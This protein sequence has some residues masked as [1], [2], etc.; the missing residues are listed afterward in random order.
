MLSRDRDLDSADFDG[1]LSFRSEVFFFL[2]EDLVFTDFLA[3][4]DLLFDFDLSFFGM[5]LFFFF[6]ILIALTKLKLLPSWYESKLLRSLLFLSSL[7]GDFCLG[8]FWDLIDFDLLLRFLPFALFFPGVLLRSLFLGVLLRSLFLGVLIPS[9]DFE[10]FFF[11][12]TL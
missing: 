8:D 2:F 12:I 1:D 6:S 11:E 9:L 3:D 4:L 5:L 10:R 7:K